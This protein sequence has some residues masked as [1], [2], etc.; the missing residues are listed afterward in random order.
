[1]KKFDVRTPHCESCGRVNPMMD[2]GY[3]TCCNELVCTGPSGS[4]Y[5]FGMMNGRHT[6]P[7]CFHSMQH[8]WT[9]GIVEHRACCAF[10]AEEKFGNE[11]FWKSS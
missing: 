3:T 9:N 7:I 6:Q 5:S 8:T 1:M 4:D 11:N 2:D 10:V